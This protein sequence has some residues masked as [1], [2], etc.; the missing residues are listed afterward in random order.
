M[1]C[2]PSHSE[3]QPPAE[4]IRLSEV[5][6]LTGLPRSTIY[7]LMRR[8][9][10]PRQ[11]P[12]PHGTRSAYWYRAEVVAWAE[13]S[14]LKNPRARKHVETRG[15]LHVLDVCP[16]AQDRKRHP[17]SISKPKQKRAP[18][19]A[20]AMNGLIPTGI[21]FLGQEVYRHRGSGLLLLAIG[22]WP[23]QLAPSMETEDTS[24]LLQ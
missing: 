12:K 24:R 13:G 17:Q 7:D 2:S 15:S 9:L 4:R 23:A 6:R 8:G 11:V 21:K 1:S 20:V 3:R 10:F 22:Y 5:R 16:G 18:E 19:P 14:R